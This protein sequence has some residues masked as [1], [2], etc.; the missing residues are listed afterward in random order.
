MHQVFGM[1]AFENHPHRQQI[2]QPDRC[3]AADG[4]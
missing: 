3:I 1:Q 4:M 2:G